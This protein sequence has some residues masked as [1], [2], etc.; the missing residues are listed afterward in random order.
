M[1]FDSELEMVLAK[2]ELVRP[3]T[4]E[5]IR[6]GVV[7]TPEMLL[8]SNSGRDRMK[9]WAISKIHQTSWSRG[10]H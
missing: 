3:V 8:E 7:W 4:I 9:I 5:K 2:R 6:D 10:L 1:M